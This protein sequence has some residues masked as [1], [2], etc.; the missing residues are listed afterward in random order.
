MRMGDRCHDDEVED[1]YR[2]I[3]MQSPKTGTN[4]EDTC[5]I[6]GWALAK[7]TSSATSMGPGM[8]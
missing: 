1:A 2:I 4:S 3:R 8:L 6:E 7:S 5:D